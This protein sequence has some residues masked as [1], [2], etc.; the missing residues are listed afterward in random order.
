MSWG[1]WPNENKIPEYL[2]LPEDHPLVVKIREIDALIKELR[3]DFKFR[4]DVEDIDT[5]YHADIKYSWNDEKIRCFILN[6]AFGIA[7]NKWYD[8]ADAERERKAK[9]YREQ[10]IQEEK[11]RLAMIEQNKIN[12]EKKLLAELKAKYES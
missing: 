5:G 7:K 2:E 6:E 1:S 3:L 4:G 12:Q 8:E 9:E 10:K 11:D